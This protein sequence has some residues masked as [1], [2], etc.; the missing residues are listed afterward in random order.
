QPSAGALAESPYRGL[1]AFGVQD[2]GWFFGREA[3]TAQVLE[4]MGRLVAGG[5]VLVVSGGSG[6]GESALL[7]VRVLPQIRRAGLAGAAQAGSWPCL[8][9]TPT[10]APLDELALR[11]AALAGADAAAV[12]RGL[13][14]DP[15]GFAL[16]ARQAALAA[17]PGL[18][19]DL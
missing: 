4:R 17:L 10:H 8:V 15:A 5:G 7:A 12:R 1:K 13:D 3:A 11:T 2:A 19:Q 9:F 14:A 18:A 6:A 16:T